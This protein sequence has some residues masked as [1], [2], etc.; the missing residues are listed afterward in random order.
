[1]FDHDDYYN[2]DDG[3]DGGYDN[4][5]SEHGQWRVC[6]TQVSLGPTYGLK[7]EWFLIK[8]NRLRS[9]LWFKFQLA[10]KVDIGNMVSR[11]LRASCLWI[12]PTG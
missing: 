6:L 10:L 11:F 1:M 12:T 2:Y 9:V 4:G 7:P 8:Y 3:D 5:C